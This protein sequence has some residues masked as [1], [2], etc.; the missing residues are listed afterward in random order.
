MKSVLYFGSIY[1]ALATYDALTIFIKMKPWS[2]YPETQKALAIAKAFLLFRGLIK[3]L[4]MLT[5]YLMHC[6]INR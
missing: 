5:T 3:Q 1:S 4:S 2:E 6:S